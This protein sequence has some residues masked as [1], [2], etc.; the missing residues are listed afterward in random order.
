MILCFPFSIKTSKCSG[1]CNNVNN[2]HAKL[3]VSDVVKNFK[4]FNLMSRTNE[5][6]HIDWHETRKCE[7]RLDASVCNNKK[8]LNECKCKLELWIQR[9]VW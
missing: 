8:L 7:C 5:T 1:S 6:R 4:V 9:I 3:C 2:P